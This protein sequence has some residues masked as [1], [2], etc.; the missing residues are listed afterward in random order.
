MTGVS[1]ILTTY[2]RPAALGAVLASA[3]ALDP[4]PLEV[5]VADDGSDG[6]TAGVIARA[7]ARFPVPLHHVWQPDDG[8]RAAASRNR[9]AAHAKGDL[10]VF[11]DGDCLLRPGL[12]GEHLRLAEPGWTVAGNRVLL[13]QALSAA[14]ERGDADPLAWRADEW[15]AARARGDVG[16]LF[17]LSTLPG[18]WW[19]RLR[20]RQWLSF[21]T[22]NAGI[23][24]E[25]FVGVNGFEERI[26]GWGF[27]D[28]DLVIRLLNAGI[29]IKSGR[30]ATAVLH[31]WHPESPRDAAAANRRLA[32]EAFA[33][34]RVRAEIGLAERAALGSADWHAPP[35][36]A[37]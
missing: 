19:R 37:T 33:E 10:L 20:G 21:R 31:L 28:S 12:I 32:L 6:R 9:A 23:W 3:A 18:H 5:V 29:R 34:R 4:A 26:R 14:V 7:S 24:R 36:P 13:G 8:F 15:K 17:P 22:C 16:R 11:V 30:F 1:L 2:N 35:A 27:E 25:D